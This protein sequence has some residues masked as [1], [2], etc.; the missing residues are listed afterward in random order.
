MEVT[1]QELQALA[2]ERVM[3]L[4]HIMPQAMYQSF[5]DGVEQIK[6][7]LRQIGRL[8]DPPETMNEFTAV[9]E[10]SRNFTPVLAQLRVKKDQL[11]ALIVMVDSGIL[12]D[13]ILSRVVIDGV[14]D[15]ELM[16]LDFEKRLQR[17]DKIIAQ[18]K[19]TF[20]PMVRKSNAGVMKAMNE[21]LKDIAKMEVSRALPSSG[22]AAGDARRQF[23]RDLS[24][25]RARL[26]SLRMRRTSVI[27]MLKEHNA[28]RG[29][30]GMELISYESKVK[31]MQDELD[32]AEHLV[33]SVAE[34]HVVP[35]ERQLSASALSEKD[36][37]DA[38][39]ESDPSGSCS[40]SEE[41]TSSAT[42]SP[43]RA[44]PPEADASGDETPVFSAQAGGLGGAIEHAMASSRS[45]SK[46]N[47]ESD[48]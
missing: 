42:T 11:R 36:H 16:F 20:A 30:V 47:R 7:C 12:K 41:P 3:H 18:H 2:D 1:L 23:A 5:T 48:D 25:H 6:G 33:E 28:H 22:S 21:L 15:F 39:A 8:P 37:L 44:R 4:A 35:A 34:A 9:Q 38:I 19:D 32:A 27:S 46:E 13:F 29:S 10:L 43:R 26:D 40:G 45:T 31:T 14:L 17:A 24:E